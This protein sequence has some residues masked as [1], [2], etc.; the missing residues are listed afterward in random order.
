MDMFDLSRYE[1]MYETFDVAHGIDHIEMTRKRAAALAKK[2]APELEELVYIAATLHDIGLVG[3]R[4]D[5]EKRGADLIEKDLDLKNYL[6]EEKHK[7]VVEAIAEHRASTGNPKTILGK[8]VSD[9]DRISSTNSSGLLR[10]NYVYRVKENP[11]MSEDEKLL[12]SA[13]HLKE[14]FGPGC[15]GS[16]TYFEETAREIAEMVNPII[17]AYDAKDVAKLASILKG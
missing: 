15:R 13:K 1:K 8:I 11:E 4:E 10:R 5:H 16:R 6:G 2:Y 17:E 9:A 12:D 7:M 14:K 3:G